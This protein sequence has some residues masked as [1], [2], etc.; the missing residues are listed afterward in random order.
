MA[1]TS[2]VARTYE[3]GDINE[4]PV[5]ASTTIYEGSTV[6]DNA[7]GYMRGL[8]AGDP[9]RG[10]AESKVDNS[11]GSAGD[12]NVRVNVRGKIQLSVSGLAI[13]DVDAKIYA[14]DDG[15]FTKTKG[16]N[17]LIGTVYRYVSSGVGIIDFD[18]T[19]EGKLALDI[20]DGTLIADDAVSAEHLDSG[21]LPFYITMYAGEHTTAGGAAAEAITVSGVLATDLVLVTLH[22]AGA[23]PRTIVTVVASADTVTVTFSADPSTDHVVTYEVLRAVS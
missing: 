17:T 20:I 22:T 8:V 12:L 3:L 4:L 7:S 15:T 11:S 13:T 16:S 6:G 1:L 9:F 19:A 10:F 5:A 23:T 21:I 14:S 18:A 2:N